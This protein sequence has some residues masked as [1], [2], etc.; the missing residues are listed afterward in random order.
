MEKT[1]CKV[2]NGPKVGIIKSVIKKT[3]EENIECKLGNASKV[4]LED[5]IEYNTTRYY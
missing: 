3:P 2:C 4:S 5:K 1:E